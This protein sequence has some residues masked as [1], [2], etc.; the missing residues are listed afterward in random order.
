MTVPAAPRAL[1][2]RE[3]GRASLARQHL[4]TPADRRGA[5]A[6]TPTPGGLHDPSAD[7]LA[8]IT[9]LVGL[10]SQAPDPP[11]V[12]LWTRLDA[13]DPQTLS[14]L[15]T[16]RHVVRIA[17]MRGTVHLVTA[18]DAPVLHALLRPLFVRQLRTSSQ[19]ARHLLDLDLDDLAAA[20]RDALHA[21]PLSPADLGRAL[22]PR[23]PDV[24]PAAL[25]QG[26]RGLLPL[27]QVPPRGV[28]RARG[29][30]GT[31][32]TTAESWLG[33]TT[34][35]LTDTDERRSVLAAVALRY[36]AAFGPAGVADIQRWS[37]LTALAGVV[38]A[39]R[40][41]LVSFTGPDGRELLDL[42]DAPRPSVDTPAPVRFL[43]AWDNLLL[44]HVNRERIITED[45]RAAM[46]SVNGIVAPSLIVDGAV[47]GRWDLRT[48]PGSATLEVTLLVARLTAAQREQT[49]AEGLRLLALLAGPTAQVRVVVT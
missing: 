24:P 43:P 27:V 44:S 48:A 25:A 28:W 18:D 30:T 5:A 49:E 22:A 31:R 15:L 35:E 3:L 20:G 6:S 16:E 34:P 47:V 19:H 37:G 45:R 11:Y 13:F 7:V 32:W 17:L 21:A 40:P 12:G 38:D 14:T 41:Q 8:E 26:V 39:L 46:F 9:H 23:W 1:S 33:R 36:L 4:L 2:V 42:P 29:G 10:Q